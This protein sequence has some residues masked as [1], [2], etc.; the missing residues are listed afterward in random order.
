MNS[1][2]GIRPFSFPAQTYIFINF[3]KILEYKV[4]PRKKAIVLAQFPSKLAY[5]APWTKHTYEHDSSVRSCNGH[6]KSNVPILSNSYLDDKCKVKSLR[7]KDC[8]CQ[9]CLLPRLGG[10]VEHEYWQIEDSN[11]RNDQVHD[12]KQ[13][14]TA[15]FQIKENIWNRKACLNFIHFMH[16]WVD[17]SNCEEDENVN[18]L[19]WNILE[20]TVSTLNI[21]FGLWSVLIKSKASTYSRMLNM[22]S[23]DISHWILF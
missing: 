7:H 4:C 22:I 1:W 15:N 9:S 6:K 18:I 10:Q 21:N 20:F 16:F 14:L 12:V 23:L 11:T 5:L 3:W 2:S 13:W 19:Y 17:Y 8:D